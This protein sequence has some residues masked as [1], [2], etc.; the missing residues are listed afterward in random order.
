MSRQA[1]ASDRGKMTNPDERPPA[2]SA[3]ARAIRDILAT[4]KAQKPR[5]FDAWGSTAKDGQSKT[6]QKS[7]P[8]A[9]PDQTA[10]QAG[11]RDEKAFDP[12]KTPARFKFDNTIR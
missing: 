7:V 5:R 8:N 12:D 2:D 4:P 10:K 6:E 3:Y 11:R 1:S 9:Q